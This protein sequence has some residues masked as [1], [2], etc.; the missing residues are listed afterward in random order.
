MR[1]SGWLTLTQCDSG[2]SA[3]QMNGKQLGMPGK[4]KERIVVPMA[5]KPG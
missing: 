3:F 4:Y 2:F 5:A 1:F